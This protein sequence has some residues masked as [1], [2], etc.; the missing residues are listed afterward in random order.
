M[1]QSILKATGERAS[2]V[3]KNVH[4]RLGGAEYQ[5][6]AAPPP[7]YNGG[8]TEAS[9]SSLSRTGADRGAPADGAAGQLSGTMSGMSVDLAG[10]DLKAEAARLL[11]YSDAVQQQMDMGTRRGARLPSRMR[12]LAPHSARS[13]LRSSCCARRTSFWGMPCTSCARI[14]A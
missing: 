11:A 2:P 7:A 14:T 1:S 5:A 12:R 9:A 3:E 6:A 4:V 13:A 10:R 8:S